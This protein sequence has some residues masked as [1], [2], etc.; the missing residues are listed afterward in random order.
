MSPNSPPLPTNT[1]CIP[2]GRPVQITDAAVVGDGDGAGGEEADELGLDVGLGDASWLG[3][4]G[5]LGDGTWLAL[6]G[7]GLTCAV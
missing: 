4:A 5:W 7:S 6:V 2:A 1:V 3:D